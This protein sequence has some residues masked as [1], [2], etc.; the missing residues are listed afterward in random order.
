MSSK[1]PSITS[2]ARPRDVIL[3]TEKQSGRKR[4]QHHYR[5]MEYGESYR[6][7]AAR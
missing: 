5:E 2:S 7:T 1:R 6:D 3:G 4:R